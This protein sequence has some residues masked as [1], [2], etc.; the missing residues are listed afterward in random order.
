MFNI[1]K[2]K[3]ANERVVVI[4]TET[5]GL[6]SFDRIVSLAYVELAGTDF[7]PYAEHLIF[8]P[9]RKSH[10]DALKV[11]GWSDRILRAQDSFAVHA[12]ALRDKFESADLI[13]AHN[14]AFDLRFVNAEFG[15]CNLPSIATE[16]FC[17]M[18]L[19]REVWPG[20]PASLDACISRAGA[21]RASSKHSAYEDAFL[22]ANIYR[23][24]KGT[25]QWMMPEGLMTPTNFRP[26][27]DIVDDEEA[28]IR[29]TEDLP[30]IGIQAAEGMVG[31]G[32]RTSEDVRLASDEQLLSLPGIGRGKIARIRQS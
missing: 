24:Y 9:G 23:F 25:K 19:A 21:K 15:R 28:A 30:G 4:D 16:S 1:F 6:S 2:K 14:V 22:T 17:T 11:H 29:L 13:V 27:P 3:R 18:E 26:V 8:S 31:I 12:G 7:E 20:Q 32:L 10:K 5:T